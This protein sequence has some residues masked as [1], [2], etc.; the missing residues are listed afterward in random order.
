MET[1][2]LRW[3]D[4]G[5]GQW[6]RAIRQPCRQRRTH[7]ALNMEEQLAERSADLLLVEALPPGAAAV[8]RASLIIGDEAVSV[9][10]GA[11]ERMRVVVLERALQPLERVQ[12][13]TDG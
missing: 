9:L 12:V 11:L 1:R 13:E 8:V 10:V 6:A 4:V 3:G 2:R 7:Q 5:H